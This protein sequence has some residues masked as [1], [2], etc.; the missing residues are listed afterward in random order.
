[1]CGSC[2]R[3]TG[4]NGCTSKRNEL[5]TFRRQ[6]VT[7]YNGTANVQLKS[8]LKGEMNTLRMLLRDMSF[9]PTKEFINGYKTETNATVS[10]LN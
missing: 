3:K 2:M 8:F 6:L 7:L 10:G 1:M 5:R 9:C 4:G